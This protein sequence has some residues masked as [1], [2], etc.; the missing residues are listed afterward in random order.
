MPA[1]GD[2]PSGV[3][4]TGAV[5]TAISPG[6]TIALFNETV[7]AL[8]A[9]IVVARAVGLSQSDQ[10]I[11][12]FIEF[13]SAP[14][15]SLQILGSNKAPAAVFNLNDWYVLFTSTNKSPD[16]Y[17]DTGRFLYYCAYEA[18]QSGGGKLTVIAQ[19]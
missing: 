7:V 11:T 18:S 5:P 10:G 17:T 3:G 19:R 1:Y 6:D 14:T 2:I 16:Y 4:T 8:E 9:S 15:D 12:F 13:A